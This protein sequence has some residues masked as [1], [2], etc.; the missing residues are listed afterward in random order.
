MS[1]KNVYSLFINVLVLF[2][3]SI[4]F[5]YDNDVKNNRIK[6]RISVCYSHYA[7]T[8]SDMSGDSDE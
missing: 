5:L 3:F 7:V 2:N 1:S 4:V 6:M 8:Y